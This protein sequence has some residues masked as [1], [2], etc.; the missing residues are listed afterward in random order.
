MRDKLE[1]SI[2]MLELADNKIS[3]THEHDIA[4][5]MIDSFRAGLRT[6]VFENIAEK[7]EL[8]A[9]LQTFKASRDQ[10]EILDLEILL[11]DIV[12]VFSI[13]TNEDFRVPEG[14]LDQRSLTSA[15]SKM[16]SLRRHK[17]TASSTRS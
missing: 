8:A 3:K 1:L 13:K 11:S 9:V 7:N 16:K 5:R 12:G 6:A 17:T 15:D 4:D 2:A 10:G 14:H